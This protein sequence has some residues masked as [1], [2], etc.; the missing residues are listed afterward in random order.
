MLARA[1]RMLEVRL[2]MQSG[3]HLVY[4]LNYIIL[5]NDGML[6]SISAFANVFPS[7]ALSDD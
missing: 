4:I 6:E 3:M 5:I 1:R 7:R 2:G